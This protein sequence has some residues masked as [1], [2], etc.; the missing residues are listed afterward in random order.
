MAFFWPPRGED[1]AN[2]GT[3]P[4]RNTFAWLF[5][6][7]EGQSG[8]LDAGKDGNSTSNHENSSTALGPYISILYLECCWASGSASLWQERTKKAKVGSK[9][10]EPVC[11]CDS[12]RKLRPITRFNSRGG[13]GPA[14]Q[15]RRARMRL[16]FLKL[17][18]ITPVLLSRRE[19][20]L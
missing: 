16:R 13:S 20:P 15:R 6:A 11:D 14:K 12:D 4:A 10:E 2:R 8:F 1:S 9:Q 19:E 17:R 18:P 3:F 5:L 7:T